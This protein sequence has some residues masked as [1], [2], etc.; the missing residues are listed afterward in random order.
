[1]LK[2]RYALI[3]GSTSGIG[4]AIAEV[5]AENGAKVILHAKD[6]KKLDAAVLELEDKGFDVFGI[7]FDVGDQASVKS[8]FMELKKKTKQLDILVNNAGVMEVGALMSISEQKLHELFATNTFG[9]FFTS[10]LASRMM[11]KQKSGSI[12]NIGSVMG[13]RGEAFHSAYAATKAALSALTKSLAKEFAPF[14][15]RCNTIAPG[16]V[17]TPMT[18]SMS[19]EEREKFLNRIDLKRFADP[20]EVAN[21]ALFLASD[22]AS[23]ITGKTIEVDGGMSE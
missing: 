22:L 9:A 2:N 3:T 11:M 6:T 16:V 1:L 20:K 10:Q 8:G 23:Y 18:E 5:F 7:S 13:E 12:I 15:I 4:K 19:D 17:E 21:V 14:S